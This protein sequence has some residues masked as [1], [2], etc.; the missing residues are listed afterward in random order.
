M[1]VCKKNDV[2]VSWGELGWG[3]REEGTR[4]IFAKWKKIV[5]G[6]VQKYRSRYLSCGERFVKQN[7]L[8]CFQLDY[9]NV[10]VI[11][12]VSVCPA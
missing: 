10:C 4:N 3:G 8:P 12:S 9:I 11:E 2:G 1:Y 6:L 7:M 5:V